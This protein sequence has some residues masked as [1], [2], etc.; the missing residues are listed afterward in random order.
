V[1]PIEDVLDLHSFQPRDVQ[2]VVRDYLEAA[3]AAGFREVRLVHGKGIGVQRERVRA[4]LA[5]HACVESFADAPPGRGHWGAT[6]VRLCGPGAGPRGQE[7]D[8]PR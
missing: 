8:P 2:D 5:G 3:V 1:L 4:L 6:V 7:P